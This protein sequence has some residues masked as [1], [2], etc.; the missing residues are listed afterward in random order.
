MF[1]KKASNPYDFLSG[2][3]SPPQ[4]IRN[5][6]SVIRNHFNH[7]EK[8]YLS[9]RQELEVKINQATNDGVREDCEIELH[10]HEHFFERVYRVSTLLIL[11]S[12]L[13][14]LM[15][16]ICK[17]KAATKNMTF[18]PDKYSIF[19]FQSY[20]KRTTDISFSQPEIEKQWAIITKL[21]ALRNA[22]VH[23]EG[24]L[25]QYSHLSPEKAN[26]LKRIINSTPGLSMYSNTILISGDYVERSCSAVE[27]FLLLIQ[28]N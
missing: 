23:S 12:L 1:S 21:N 15:A 5:R 24:D 10:F 17:Y 4:T 20:L 3:P 27:K 25:E 9:E 22:L 13:E 26:K 8:L 11:Y 16:K 2:S 18:Q 28:E 6:I 19:S 14:N 7:S